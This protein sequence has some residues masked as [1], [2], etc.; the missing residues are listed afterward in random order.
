MYKKYFKRIIDFIFSLLLIIILLPLFIFIYIILLITLKND[1]I[2]KQVRIG[3]NKKNY[4]MYKFRTM[5]ND[6]SI[7]D[8][9]R[10]TKFGKILRNSSLDELPQLFNVLKGDMSL[11]GPR[12]FI[13]GEIL[14]KNV[15]IDDIRYSVKPG[16]T[17]YAQVH[18]KRNLSHKMKIYYDCEYTKKMS[19]ILDMKILFSTILVMFQKNN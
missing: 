14:P 1:I 19:F 17:G 5:I 12:P 13:K 2:F 11:V 15:N 7:P 10:I 4:T 3:K 9:D 16:I 6:T 18:G 8:K